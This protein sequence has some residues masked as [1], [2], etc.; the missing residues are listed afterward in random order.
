M[1]KFARHRSL[2]ELKAEAKRR[3]WSVNDDQYQRQGSDFVRVDFRHGRVSGSALYSTVNGRFFGKTK[4]GVEFNSDD[5]AR[6]RVPYF[7]ALLACCYV[8]TKSAERVG[9]LS[10]ERISLEVRKTH[11]YRDGWSYLDERQ[12]VGTAVITPFRRVREAEDYDTGPVTVARARIPAGQDRELSIRALR[13]EFS[14]S[15]CQHEHDCCGCA[16]YHASVRAVP[17]RRREF[18]IRVSTSYNY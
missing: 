12:H 7:A 11:R 16:S 15:G 4:T 13:D 5:S 10:M 18:S 6:D 8:S 9:G 3:G 1:Q 17:G 2:K 14:G